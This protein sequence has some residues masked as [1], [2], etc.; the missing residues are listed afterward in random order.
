MVVRPCQSVQDGRTNTTGVSLPP[1]PPANDLPLIGDNGEWK[2][3]PWN[4]K[5]CFFSNVQWQ[6]Q[7]A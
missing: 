4:A 5:L 6:Q 2:M 7:M 3:T 1:P